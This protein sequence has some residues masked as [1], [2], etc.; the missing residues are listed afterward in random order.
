MSKEAIKE[1]KQAAALSYNTPQAISSLSM[2]LL[3]GELELAYKYPNKR[4]Q[5]SIEL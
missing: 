1:Y 2:T 5:R 3:F 4:E